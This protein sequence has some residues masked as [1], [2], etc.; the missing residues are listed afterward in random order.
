MNA[1]LCINIHMFMSMHA[2]HPVGMRRCI[3]SIVVPNRCCQ[4]ASCAGFWSQSLRSWRCCL[5]VIGSNETTYHWFESMFGN[6]T[7]SLAV[8]GYADHG[9]SEPGVSLGYLSQHWAFL[10]GLFG[11][12]TLQMLCEKWYTVRMRTDGLG[13]RTR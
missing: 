10:L 11:N 3:R 1:K 2:R 7:M 12:V 9:V 13:V 6:V 4:E 5:R 8:V